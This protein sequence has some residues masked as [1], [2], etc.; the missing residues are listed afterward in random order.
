MT[1]KSDERSLA[2]FITG[3]INLWVDTAAI[4]EQLVFP[5][6][7]KVFGSHGRDHDE[8]TTYGSRQ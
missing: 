2:T 4:L 5:K 6:V 1:R 7:E 3:Q 8:K